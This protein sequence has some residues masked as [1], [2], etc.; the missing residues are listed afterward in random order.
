MLARAAAT[1]R[2]SVCTPARSDAH[3]GHDNTS[4]CCAVQYR[5]LSEQATCHN[6]HH[7]V[8]ETATAMP[9]E[10]VPG[11]ILYEQDLTFVLGPAAPRPRIRRIRVV[12][13]S[14]LFRFCWLTF[15]S[16]A[17]PPLQDPS[18]PTPME[19]CGAVVRRSPTTTS[20]ATEEHGH[21]SLSCNSALSSAFTPACATII[22]MYCAYRWLLRRGLLGVDGSVSLALRDCK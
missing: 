7:R 8:S 15:R 13:P 6:Q 1:L 10:C 17:S 20:R 9:N 21:I 3:C 5:Q 12:S 4:T 16:V 18:S 14:L 19:S 22:L 2:L 11:T